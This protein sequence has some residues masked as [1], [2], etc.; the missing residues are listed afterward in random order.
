MDNAGVLNFMD[1]NSLGS[2]TL[3]LSAAFKKVQQASK[4]TSQDLL[5]SHDN[6]ALKYNKLYDLYLSDTSAQGSL[7]YGISRQHGYSANTSIING[8]LAN[9]DA[10]SVSKLLSYNYNYGGNSPSLGSA[11]GLGPTQTNPNLITNTTFVCGTLTTNHEVNF[12]LSKFK[13]LLTLE[14]DISSKSLASFGHL[15]VQPLTNKLNYGD[16]TFDCD[17]F[18]KKFTPKPLDRKVVPVSR[19]GGKSAREGSI[20]VR[21]DSHNPG[22][23]NL[24]KADI[25]FTNNYYGNLLGTQCL[26]GGVDTVLASTPTAITQSHTPSSVLGTK[27]TTLRYDR[28]APTGVSSPLLGLEGVFA[29]GS[30]LSSFWVS[31]WSTNG[32]GVRLAPAVN[33]LGRRSNLALPAIIEYA[34][35]DFRD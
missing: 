14:G 23:P 34:E 35:Y 32:V 4:T 19:F 29:P 12:D 22:N 7:G 28:F 17:F 33:Y 13:T 18:Y 24:S 15:P 2:T 31:L 3:N 6:F 10:K 25:N 21:G 27:L 16:N 30:T 20:Q 11:D 8:S 5:S 9:L 26:G 1:F